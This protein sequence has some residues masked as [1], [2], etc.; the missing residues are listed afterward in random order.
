MKNSVPVD[1]AG[2]PGS[3]DREIGGKKELIERLRKGTK[4]VRLM[5]P[6]ILGDGIDSLETGNDT[7]LLEKHR[8]AAETGRLSAFVPASGAATRM[9]QDLIR[10]LRR[11]CAEHEALERF[12]HF[13][14]NLER[15]P[16]FSPLEQVMKRDGLSLREKISRDE[17]RPI[18][19]YLLTD[20]GLNLA[21]TPKALV[22]FHRYG[23]T[24]RTALEEHLV[25]AC[26]YLRDREGVCRL[27]FTFAPGRLSSA[28]QF[29]D[30]V[31]SPYEDALN[32]RLR[33][34]LS[35]QDPSTDTPALCP[36]GEL[37]RLTDGTLTLR[38]GGHGAL[39]ENLQTSKGDIVFIKNIDNVTPDHLKPPVIHYKKLLCGR[40][41]ELESE[42][43]RYL[44]I[45]SQRRLVASEC[46]E[47]FEFA[48]GK[49]HTPILPDPSSMNRD[50]TQRL[51]LEY[52]NRPL[53][54]CGVVRN[55]GEPGGGPFWIREPTG[56]VSLQIVES[57]QVDHMEPEQHDIWH[58]ATH[59]NP[60]DLVCGLRDWMGQPFTLSRY[61]DH[62]ACIITEKH[63]EGR[64][65]RV[66]EL[67]GLWNGSMAMWH[68]VFIEV[69]VSTFQP[70]KKVEDLLKESHLPE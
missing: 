43:R 50:E 21:D 14:R 2:E 6:A 46:E 62:E 25:E 47:L 54:V 32:V 55:Q 38:P 31:L 30:N 34:Q 44:R 1:S 35:T 52:L 26:S 16:F 69:P 33:I 22:P 53:R 20:Q 8:N 60:V 61:V 63:H 58:S 12:E 66:L 39:L 42:L 5:R 23:D 57:A 41:L 13:K 15:F 49:L 29:I 3:D 51:L 64:P 40:F 17:W 9:F 28:R 10:I 70:V 59:F 7:R 68:T 36:N 11:N 48:T 56:N 65:I 67:P 19:S 27:H 18:L 4:Y 45:M 24:V 37:C